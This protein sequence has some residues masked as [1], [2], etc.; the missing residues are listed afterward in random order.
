MSRLR[1]LAL[2]LLLAVAA[3][4][5]KQTPHPPLFARV[6]AVLP[7]E[8]AP[9]ADRKPAGNTPGAIVATTL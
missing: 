1:P 5:S 6:V 3:C 8:T 4:G 7:F 2:A 9:A